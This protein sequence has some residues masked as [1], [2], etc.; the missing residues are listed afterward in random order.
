MPGLP[1]NE[2]RVETSISGAEVPNPTTTMP[3]TSADMPKCRAA[4][5]A[6]S[7][8]LSADHNSRMRPAKTAMNALVMG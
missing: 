4:E 2:A 1:C 8:N 3:M 5:A 6:P 7:M